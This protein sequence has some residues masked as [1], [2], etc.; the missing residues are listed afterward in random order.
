LLAIEE[1]QTR[2]SLRLEGKQAAEV[3]RRGRQARPDVSRGAA[4]LAQAPGSPTISLA[5]LRGFLQ[6]PVESALKR[7]LRLY[8]EDER[9]LTDDEPFS[10]DASFSRQVI[11]EALR[12]FIQ[13]A[14][15]ES[16]E[17]ALADW[18]PRF[19]QLHEE[20][21]WRGRVPEGAFADVDRSRFE[22]RLQE[23]IEEPGGLADFVR[24]RHGAK[25]IGPVLL[26]ES[27]TPLGART[28]FAALSLPVGDNAVRLVGAM[29]LVWHSADALDVLVLTN[30]KVPP[31]QLSVPLLDPVLFYLALR[32]SNDEPGTSKK[33]LRPRSWLGKRVFRV[34]I[35]HREGL[36]SFHYH[37]ED[38]TP[39]EA[40]DYLKL[41]A[42]DFLDRSCFDLLPFDIIVKD[43]TLRQA[44]ESDVES[45]RTSAEYAARLRESYEDDQDSDFP[46]YRAMRLL[47]IVDAQVPEDA[48]AKVRRRFRLLER[49]PARA[50]AEDAGRKRGH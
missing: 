34:H 38:V 3:E 43:E 14:L 44:Y 2:G 16:L 40:R 41:L 26:G 27:P 12:R 24:D 47:E 13:R 35:A 21:R 33:E 50:R 30:R 49:G 4:P 8:D 42:E 29:P 10:T 22:E 37:P 20:W 39:A 45:P 11:A 46:A 17:T 15:G 32:A 6:C 1:A 5:E 36:V 18:R 9:D 19:A 25:F 28:R 7:H 48:Y 23:R 31:H